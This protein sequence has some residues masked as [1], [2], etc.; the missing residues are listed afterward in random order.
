MEMLKQMMEKT[1]PRPERVVIDWKGTPKEYR[2]K[3]MRWGNEMGVE[4]VKAKELRKL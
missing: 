4:V 3:V 2:E 1:V